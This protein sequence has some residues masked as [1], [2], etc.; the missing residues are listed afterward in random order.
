MTTKRKSAGGRHQADKLVALTVKIDHSLFM[1]LSTL[2][3]RNRVTAQEILAEALE[4]H[5]K[6]AG[7]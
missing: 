6:R 1:R 5:L 3:A 4:A 2:R 7:V